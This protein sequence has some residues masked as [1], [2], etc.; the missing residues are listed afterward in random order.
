MLENGSI[1]E[2]PVSTSASSTISSGIEGSAISIPSMEA[3]F[4]DSPGASSIFAA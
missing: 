3:A 2:T 4:I 1:M